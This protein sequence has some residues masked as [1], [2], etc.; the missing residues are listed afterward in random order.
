[1]NWTLEGN[2]WLE[3]G[4]LEA[5]RKAQA[6]KVSVHS[7]TL[8]SKTVLASNLGLGAQE[9]L[10]CAYFYQRQQVKYPPTPYQSPIPGRIFQDAYQT[11]RRSKFHQIALQH[12][13]EAW[14]KGH[15]G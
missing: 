14:L 8:F 9:E 10:T 3:H 4:V 2:Q 5:L 13:H 11:H 15:D 7:D 6:L 12:E 1:M